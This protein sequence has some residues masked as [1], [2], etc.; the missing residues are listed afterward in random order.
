M[1]SRC[2]LAAFLGFLPGQ[3][4]CFVNVLRPAARKAGRADSGMRQR[5]PSRS[6]GGLARDKTHPLCGCS[7]AILQ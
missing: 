6:L 5:D 1:A 3:H 2:S 4:T 7:G